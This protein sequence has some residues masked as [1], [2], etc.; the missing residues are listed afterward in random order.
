MGSHAQQN[1]GRR[2]TCPARVHQCG[3]GFR[4][5]FDALDVVPINHDVQYIGNS[6]IGDNQ[7]QMTPVTDGINCECSSTAITTDTQLVS[8]L[9][10]RDPPDATLL[11]HLLGDLRELHLKPDVPLLSDLIS[12]YAWPCS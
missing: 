5:N 1:H 4:D 8:R 11:E 2:G 7:M 3:N 12:A 6:G 10:T 9:N